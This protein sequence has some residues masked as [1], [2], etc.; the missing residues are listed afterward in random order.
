[1][2]ALKADDL[3]HTAIIVNDVDAAMERLTRLAGYRWL[4]PVEYSVPV[5]TPGGESVTRLRM[6]YSTSRRATANSS[7]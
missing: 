7:G 2:I 3:F 6:V 1:M 5:W 4:T